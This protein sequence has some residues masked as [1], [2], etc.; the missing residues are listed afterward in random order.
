MDP[1]DADHAILD[2][3]RLV[4]SVW[5]D[6]FDD[7]MLVR[8]DDIDPDLITL[9]R[10]AAPTLEPIRIGGAKY[11]LPLEWVLAA[12]DIW[13]LLTTRMRL[14]SLELAVI[15]P[16]KSDLAQAPVL[17]GWV[18]IRSEYGTRAHLVGEVDS[19]SA[20][21]GP[22]IQKSPLCG[23]DPDLKSARTVSRWYRLEGRSTPEDFHRK[24]GRKADGISAMAI[25]VWEAQ[26][27][28]AAEQIREGIREE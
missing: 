8:W 26:A 17:T 12:E 19:H 15:G 23:L 7:G 4:R 28:C 1:N 16:N 9:I 27:I 14:R 13:H 25:E 22:M 10:D 6:G 5:V 11:A 3:L 20:S 21:I 2:K 24:S 18:P